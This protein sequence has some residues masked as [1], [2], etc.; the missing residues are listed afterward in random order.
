ME[1]LV[2]CPAALNEQQQ[3]QHKVSG[4]QTDNYGLV[5]SAI[6]V[7]LTYRYIHSTYIH[8]RSL[9]WTAT[10]W[11]MVGARDIP[12]FSIANYH[13]VKVIVIE[14]IIIASSASLLFAAH[15]LLSRIVPMLML[16]I[17]FVIN[18]PPLQWLFCW[19]GGVLY[20]PLQYGHCNI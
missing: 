20:V 16:V 10:V 13:V 11:K 2:W 18:W 19:G 3:Q 7:Y 12:I 8:E 6:Y 14:F 15:P 5:T 1:K 17:E 9:M 4:R